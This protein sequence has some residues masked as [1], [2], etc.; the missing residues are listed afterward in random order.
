MATE[1]HELLAAEK[2]R[3]QAWD[4]LFAETMKK[5]HKAEEYYS[6]HSKSLR[7]L[8]ESDGNKAIEA[9]ASEEKP[10]ITSV[11]DTLDWALGIY[12]TA[13][14]LQFEKNLTQQRAMGTVYWRGQPLLI[15]MPVDQLLGLEARLR[16][17]RELFVAMP[18]L[19]ASRHWVPATDM[20]PYIYETRHP[21]ET[22]KTDK[23]VIPVVLSPA[24]DRHPAQVQPVQK[25]VVVGRFKTV[26]R[27]GA[28]TSVEKSEAIKVCDDLLTE[29]KQARMRANTTEVLPAKMAKTI[30]DVLL[31]PL[32]H[33]G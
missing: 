11:F 7:M 25:D 4:Q 5:F 10:V 32:K 28:A 24:S 6:G 3:N 33:V 27:S 19:D 31:E 23:Q 13:E 15:D 22:T 21:E 26:K 1:L 20:G 2:T 29:I 14:D 8:E 30:V 17:V 18:T 9:Q 16:K 12:A